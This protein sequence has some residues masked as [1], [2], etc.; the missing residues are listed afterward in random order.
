MSF[1]LFIVIHNHDFGYLI[2]LV[3]PK[4]FFNAL[5]ALLELFILLGFV[6]RKK[7][8][9]RRIVLFGESFKG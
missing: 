5:D 9:D 7:G 1:T 8:N 3:I 4:L 6:L 2:S